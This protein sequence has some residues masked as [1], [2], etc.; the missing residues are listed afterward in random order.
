MAKIGD[1]AFRRRAL[2]VGD[3]PD[4]GRS[5]VHPSAAELL[6]ISKHDRELKEVDLSS[7]QL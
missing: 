3:I 6:T 7:G 4:I 1:Q 5:G 2:I